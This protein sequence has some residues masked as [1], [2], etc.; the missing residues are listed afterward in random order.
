MWLNPH[1]T[2]DFV[3]LINEIHTLFFVQCFSNYS[4]Y[5]NIYKEKPEKSQVS[6]LTKRNADNIFTWLFNNISIPINPEF[7][8]HQFLLETLGT[9]YIRNCFHP[10]KFHLASVIN[11]KHLKRDPLNFGQ[12]VQKQRGRLQQWRL[13]LW[14]WLIQN[15]K[16]HK[17]KFS[18][19]YLR[20]R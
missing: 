5:L 11:Q 4:T 2:A 1:W 6:W 19:R 20:R 13:P 10:K 17:N 18:R 7:N 9:S 12:Q 14:R 8:F 15:P 16:R 3:T